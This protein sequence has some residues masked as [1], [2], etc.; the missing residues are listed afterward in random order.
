MLWE[1]RIFWECQIASELASK[2][3]YLHMWVRTTNMRLTQALLII[4]DESDDSDVDVSLQDDHAILLQWLNGIA[5]KCM[6][7]V[8]NNSN[9]SQ[10][11]VLNKPLDR[12]NGVT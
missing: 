3:A 2:Q 7:L 11:H 8:T 10:V 12:L 1:C 6:L 5:K 4:I 9:T